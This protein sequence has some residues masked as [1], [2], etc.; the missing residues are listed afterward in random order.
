MTQGTVRE[1]IGHFCKYVR[2]IGII[3]N[4]SNRI[5]LP[6]PLE[7]DRW[8]KRFE[9][10]YYHVQSPLKLKYNDLGAMQRCGAGNSTY[11]L[12]TPSSIRVFFDSFLYDSLEGVKSA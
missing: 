11:A 8:K 3:G 10:G 9:K 1:P 7:C 6:R 5:L 2:P 4:V 12:Q